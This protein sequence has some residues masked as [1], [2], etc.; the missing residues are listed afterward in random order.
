MWDV[1]GDIHGYAEPLFLLLRALGYD[2]IRGSWRHPSGRRRCL[3]V[4]DYID[5][6]PRIDATLNTV[7][8]MVENGDAIAVMGNHEYNMILWN[9][10]GP[11]GWLRAH[12]EVH[13]HQHH[14]TLRQLSPQRYRVMLE[15]AKTLPVW[16]QSSHIR[17]V[18]AA[19][20][21]RIVSRIAT[22][23]LRIERITTDTPY[24]RDVETLLKGV[25]LPLPAGLSYP[26]KEGVRRTKTRLRWWR[27]PQELTR[28]DG[29]V[30]LHE[31]AMPPADTLLGMNT[32]PANTLPS[33]LGY[34]DR[35]PVFIGHYWLTPPARTQTD[36][37]ACLDYSVAAQGALCAYRWDD[38]T[39]LR[40]DRFVCVDQKTGRI[41]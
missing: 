37:V 34:R 3:F 5:R 38:Q 30:A 27:S 16:W 22:P 12:S 20:N 1:I 10:M 41:L 9:T 13:L 14:Q 36:T 15:W 17:V 35:I 4:G 40:D 18:H 24:R 33:S 6:G 11:D 7:T 31:I 2:R 28:P 29:T 26:D 8:T 39:P 21:D 19:W 23:H 25:E 32:I